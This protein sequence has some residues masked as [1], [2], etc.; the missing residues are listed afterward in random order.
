MNSSYGSPHVGANVEVG[1]DAV[2]VKRLKI[3]C[4]LAFVHA[5]QLSTIPS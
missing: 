4:V 1:S 5:A 2:P 3:P